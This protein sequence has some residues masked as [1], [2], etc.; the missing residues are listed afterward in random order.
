MSIVV[1]TGAAGGVGRTVCRLLLEQGFEVHGL[2]RPEDDLRLVPLP[3][4]NVTIGYVQDA[5]AV[6][7]A[8]YGADAVV[9]CAALLPGALHLGAAAFQEVNVQGPLNV[10][11][12]A[13][14]AGL[15]QAVFFS[16]ISVIDHVGR[17]VLPGQLFDYIPYP[18]DAYLA[19]KIDAEKALRARASSFPGQVAILRPAFIYGPGNYAVWRDGLSLL[20]QGKITLIGSGR[21]PLP[22]IYVDD[23]ARFVAVLLK[24]PVAGP[25]C[26]MHILSNPEPTTIGAV[27]DFLADLLGVKRPARAPYLLVRLACEMVSLLPGRLRQGRLALLTRARV[28]QYSQGY[29]LSGTIS[30]E[31]LDSVP[32]TSWKVGLTRMVEDYLGSDLFRSA[33]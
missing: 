5:R 31:F 1:V 9:H 28:A 3:R 30:P 21:A 24:R 25:E 19:S 8:L 6:A 33:A 22:L 32:L 2:I 14:R 20:R 11:E 10:L 15:R 7:R 26:R 29:D 18:H 13:A 17:K 23:I 27:F 4:R 16:T 12:Q